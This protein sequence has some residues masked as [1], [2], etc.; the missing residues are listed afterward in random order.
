MSILLLQ[1]LQAEILFKVKTKAKEHS[2]FTGDQIV[3]VHRISCRYIYTAITGSENATEKK[4]SSL[5]VYR[6]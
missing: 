6:N 3:K 2:F 1:R 4:K 5:F